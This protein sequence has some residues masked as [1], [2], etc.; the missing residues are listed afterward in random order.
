M[1]HIMNPGKPLGRVVRE[2]SHLRAYFTSVR[3]PRVG[4]YVLVEYQQEEGEGSAG[5]VL[6]IVERSV[7]GNPM[8]D[9]GALRPEFVEQASLFG[10][11]R[12]EYMIGQ[13]RLLSWVEPLIS[14]R[15]VVAPRYPPRPSARVFEASDE[16]LQ[17]IFK[18]EENDGWIRIGRLVNHPNVPFYVNINSIVSRHLA[19]LAVTGAGKSNAVGVLLERLVNDLN[20][21][22]FVIDMHSEYAN[23]AGEEK[24]NIIEPKIHPAKLAVAEY[25]TLLDLDERATKQRMYLRKAY[26][27][28]KS[29]VE[30]SRNPDKF[31]DLLLEKLDEYYGDDR[32]KKDKGPIADLINK[33]QELK[34]RYGGRVLTPSAPMKLES[35]IEPG[36]VNIL[37]LGSVDEEVAD[38]VTYHYL[39]W[40]LNERKMRVI[41]AALDEI[42]EEGSK[43]YPVPVLAVIEEAHVLIPKKRT[44][45]TKTVAARIAREGRK[46]GVGLAL[47][48]QRPKN[49][50]EDALSQTN[51]KIILKLV[52][53]QDQK[54]V[55]AASETLSDELLQMLPSLNVGEAV[56]L[57]LMSP[58]PALVKIDKATNKVTGTDI[59]VHE[60]WRR[61]AQSSE[62]TGTDIYD[63]MGF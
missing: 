15:E 58:L 26:R 19:I 4:E 16:I 36:K 11:E 55:Q 39:N 2:T 54:Y 40:L 9:E 37:Q 57:G 63:E 29:D 47:V 5:Y 10:A 45:L 44:T 3:P 24:T 61:Y 43:G 7:I 30:S 38:V 50:D 48:S 53:P 34:E 25:F 22:A 27:D 21:T 18:R 14:R 41:A 35:I 20:G 46:F 1:A 52:E 23:I 49:V 8:L 62:G 59:K 12:H 51:N 31:L 32:Y 28:V 42:V 17:A 13:A 56:V 6:G 33:L 60:E